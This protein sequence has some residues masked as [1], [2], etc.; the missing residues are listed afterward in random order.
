MPAGQDVGQR[1]HGRFSFL[2]ALT[3][4]RTARMNFRRGQA[5][6]PSGDD[7]PNA[8]DTSLWWSHRSVRAGA[9]CGRRTRAARRTPGMVA[10]SA[11][12]RGR[13][14]PDDSG[15]PTEPPRWRRGSRTARCRASAGS[16][17]ACQAMT[18]S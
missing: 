17:G 13:T 6:G 1:I 2:M 15:R 9:R 8:C 5:P 12:Q 3:S 14:S 11:S 18:P 16:A 4:R 10:R 7:C